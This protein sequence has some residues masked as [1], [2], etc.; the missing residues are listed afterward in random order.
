MDKG[1]LSTNIP[2]DALLYHL[3][4]LA[5][6]IVNVLEESPWAIVEKRKGP[7]GATAFQ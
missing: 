5:N 4:Y 3:P 7:Y 6:V 1:K 2:R